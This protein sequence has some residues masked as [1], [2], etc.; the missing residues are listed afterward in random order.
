MD[1][2]HITYFIEVVRHKS[3]SRAAENLFVTQPVLTRCIK[4]LERELGVPLIIRNSKTFSITDAGQA[5]Y[6]DGSQLVS[7][8]RDIY[9]H[10]RD[11]KTVSEGEIRVA[12]HG[13][14][15]DMYFPQLATK[16]HQSYPGIRI[17]LKEFG[18]ID[19]VHS[20]RNGAVDLGLVML[21]IEDCE[22]LNVYPIVQDE[23]SVLVH[24][25]H[26]FASKNT[27]HI[28]ELEHQPIITFDSSTTLH[29][30]FLQMCREENYVPR[31]VYQSMM[32]NFILD[33]IAFGSCI[34]ILPAPMF[35]RFSPEYLS[36]LSMNP[37]FPWTIALITK[38]NRY[39]SFAAK[40]F[41]TY[42]QEYFSHPIRQMTFPSNEL[43]D[44]YKDY[45]ANP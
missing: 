7:A 36:C 3:F 37:Y 20:V 8:H 34:G 9:R 43:D 41:L 42:A 10:I 33:T 44:C 21:P 13:V 35:H 6:E 11:I 32:P 28:K 22:D 12:G 25:D 19:C 5:L 27:I 18:S 23:V 4:N 16:Y 40:S 30:T 15:L 31:I 24:R 45:L 2:Q 17:N 39:M 14:L 38:K 1:I 29:N 26:P